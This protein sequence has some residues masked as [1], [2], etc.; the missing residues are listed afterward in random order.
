MR[1]ERVFGSHDAVAEGGAQLRSQPGGGG[2]EKRRVAVA[3]GDAYEA[4]ER[5]IAEDAPLLNLLFVEA[6]VG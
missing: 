1:D 4:V 6:V 5:R 3:E 2:V